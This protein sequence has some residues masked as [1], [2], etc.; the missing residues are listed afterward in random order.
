MQWIII[1]KPRLRWI[2]VN[3]SLVFK[4]C[5]LLYTFSVAYYFSGKK[6][7]VMD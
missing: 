7:I 1:V 4:T 6:L 5:L 3:A 2:E